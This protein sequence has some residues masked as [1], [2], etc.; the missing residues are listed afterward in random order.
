MG[1]FGSGRWQQGKSTTDD[2]PQI[3]VRHLQRDGLLEP[4]HLFCQHWKGN[5]GCIED[6]KIHAEID[7][8]TLIY[9]HKFSNENWK[10]EQFSLYLDWTACNFGGKRAWFLCSGCW[11]RVAILYGGDN[12]A[13]R[14]CFGLSYPSQ[15]EAPFI[16]AIRKNV[17]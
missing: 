11:R 7:M 6:I 15:R 14:R 10:E 16:R 13:C 2:Y 12:F 1:G 17:V 5:D 8:L 9:K 4:G 3:D